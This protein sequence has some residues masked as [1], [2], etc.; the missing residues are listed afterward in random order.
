MGNR[1]PPPRSTAFSRVLPPSLQK[2][3]P[4]PSRSHL[5]L[6]LPQPP[7]PNLTQPKVWIWVALPNPLLGWT[8]SRAL[9]IAGPEHRPVVDAKELL[10]P[11][12]VVWGVDRYKAGPALRRA[13]H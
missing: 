9:S 7:P 4:T 10:L 1:T 8:P 6:F 13:T 11:L 5:C 3:Y 2:P 12:Q